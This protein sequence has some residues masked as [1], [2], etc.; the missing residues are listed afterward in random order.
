[1][2]IRQML[3]RASREWIDIEVPRFCRYLFSVAVLSSW[4]L[5]REWQNIYGVFMLFYMLFIC[6]YYV[7]GGGGTTVARESTVYFRKSKSVFDFLRVRLSIYYY[8]CLQLTAFHPFPTITKPIEYYVR[9][10]GSPRQVHGLFFGNQNQ[11]SKFPSQV[12]SSRGN[13]NPMLCSFCQCFEF[14]TF[15]VFPLLS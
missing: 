8:F 9:W 11:I 10:P 13:S 14:T 15:L 1:M 7:L 3:L 5:L 6:N 2:L 12:P 4:L